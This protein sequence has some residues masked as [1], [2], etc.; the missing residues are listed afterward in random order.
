MPRGIYPKPENDKRS[1]PWVCPKC[2]NTLRASGKG[3]HLRW[4]GKSVEIF[5]S[6]VEKTATCW[7]FK[8][9]LSWE[10]Y[11]RF[12]ENGNKKQYQAHRY[13]WKTLG[14]EIAEGKALLHR[15]NVRNCVNPEHLYVG[16]WKDNAQDKILAGRDPT[17][18]LNADQVREVRRLLP[19]MM[20]KDIAARMGVSAGVVSE[21]KLR[22]KYRWVTETADACDAASH[23][24]DLTKEK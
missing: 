9:T 13:A 23:A 22:K 21:I 17:A 4:C 7:L 1:L 12:N 14:L 16:D 24:D 2:E 18:L 15:C 5:W 20:Q 10:G 3:T 19:T 6:R 8:G 11:G